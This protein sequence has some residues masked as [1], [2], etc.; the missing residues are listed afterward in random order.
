VG[1]AL[2]DSPRFPIEEIVRLP[3]GVGRVGFLRRRLRWDVIDDKDVDGG[4]GG[5]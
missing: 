3:G 4:R 1:N 5:K 2:I